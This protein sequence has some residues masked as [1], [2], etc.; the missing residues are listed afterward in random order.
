M[1]INNGSAMKS[2][3]HLSRLTLALI[4]LAESSDENWIIREDV[5]FT[6]VKQINIKLMMHRWNMWGFGERLTG[7][8]MEFDA[9]LHCDDDLLADYPGLGRDS[10]EF[11]DFRGLGSSYKGLASIFWWNFVVE[12]YPI[13]DF[14]RSSWFSIDLIIARWS[15]RVLQVR[16]WTWN[17]FKY[18]VLL[19]N[20][21]SFFVRVTRILM[22]EAYFNGSA[23]E[24][25]R[26]LRELAY[27][28][29]EKWL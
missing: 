3:L 28:I 17:S 26:V 16:N 24:I 23:V 5:K 11:F 1:Y 9:R 25:H 2:V 29:S 27:H 21:G 18:S 4:A 7:T 20:L 10:V 12:L 8:S 15:W 14:N 13:C 22:F 6:A 19:L